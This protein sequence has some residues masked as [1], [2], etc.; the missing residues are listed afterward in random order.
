MGIVSMSYS[1]L[2]H[3]NE[4]RIRVEGETREELFADA[5]AGM[6]SVMRSDRQH[7]QG[8]VTRKVS[9]GALD[10]TTLLVD[11][12]NE[13]LLRAHMYHELYTK[14]SFDYC[15]EIFLEGV[16]EGTPVQAFDENIRT[17]AYYQTDV[18]TNENGYFET[19]VVFDLTSEES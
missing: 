11:F 8:S 1:I 10:Q 15:D 18:I 12:L 2:E 13:V 14:V 3:T 16:L 17:V 4:L 9:L 19:V 7:L 5:V 6:M